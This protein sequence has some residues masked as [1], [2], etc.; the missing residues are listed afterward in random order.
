M[1][2][3]VLKSLSYQYPEGEKIAFPDTKIGISQHTLIKGNSGVGKTTL[4]HLI[5]GIRKIQEGDII[6]SG[7]SIVNLTNYQ[8]DKFRAQH[9][10]LVFQ[11]HLFIPSLSVLENISLAASFGSKAVKTDQIT[12]Y[13]NDFNIGHLAHKKP[14]L[15]S[16]GEQQRASIARALINRPSLIIADEPSSALDDENTHRVIGT[17]KEAASRNKS[18]LIV[19]SHDQRIDDYFDLTIQLS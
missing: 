10:G 18:T 2:S 15:L 13:L 5:A 4:L 9:I 16:I 11:K 3:L 8:L 6:I 1:A 7:E 12:S 14:E 19:V 17:L